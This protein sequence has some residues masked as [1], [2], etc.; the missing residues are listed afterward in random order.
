M[1]KLETFI[2]ILMKFILNLAMHNIFINFFYK[3]IM[4]NKTDL[5]YH[6]NFEHYFDLYHHLNKNFNFKILIF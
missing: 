2:L 3:Q 4:N 1:Q 5:K 6:L